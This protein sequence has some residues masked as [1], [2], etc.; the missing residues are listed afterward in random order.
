MKSG[1]RNEEKNQWL[2][3]TKSTQKKRAK[4]VKQ[5][6]SYQDKCDKPNI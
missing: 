5:F 1:R 3:K 2:E 6:E 4:L